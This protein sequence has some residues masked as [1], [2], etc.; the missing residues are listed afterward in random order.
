MTPVRIMLA[1]AALIGAGCLLAPSAA[2]P[3]AAKKP[4]PISVLIID[5]QNVSV[6]PW[7]ETTP[8]IKKA[9]EATGRFKVAVLTSPPAKSPKDA[10]ANFK[11][12]F[13][14][15]QAVF[16]NYAG[17]PWPQDVENAFEKYM[18]E[19]GGLVVYHFSSPLSTNGTL[20]PR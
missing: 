14:K 13:S 2:Q 1:A 10:W 6:H 18:A 19:G 11:P 8:L 16:L 9:F 15:Y 7:K 4:A 17:D 12:E 3:P 5:G 20:S